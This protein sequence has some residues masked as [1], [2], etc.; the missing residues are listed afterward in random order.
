MRPCPHCG[1]AVRIELAPSYFE[2]RGPAKQEGSDAADEERCGNHY[3]DTSDRPDTGRVQTVG[4]MVR[5]LFTG[6]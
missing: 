3:L 4:A 5:G 6:Q 1:S 2:C